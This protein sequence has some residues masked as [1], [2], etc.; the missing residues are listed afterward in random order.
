MAAGIRHN[1]RD[2]EQTQEEGAEL[3]RDARATGRDEA[4]D[5]AKGVGIV[6]V[7]GL[8]L[9][10]RSAS[11]FHAKF[12][13]AWWT[14]KWINLF[15]NFCVPLF[16]LISAILLARSASRPR[17]S[18]PL[19]ANR[20]PPSSS[21]WRRFAWRR[22]RSVLFPLLIW[23]AIFWLLRAFVRHDVAVMR[24]GYWLDYKGR[25]MDL[26][27]GKAEFHLYFLSILAQFCILLPFLAILFGKFDRSRFRKFLTS[28]WFGLLIAILMQSAA[29]ALQKE[30]RFQW[31]GATVFWYLSILIPGV[32][33]GMN[34]KAW[35]Q[36]RRQTW[37]VWAILAAVGFAVFGTNSALDLQARPTNGTATNAASSA[38][39]LGMSFLILAFL[40]LLKASKSSP[41]P[42]SPA[43]WGGAFRSL[44]K[45]MGELSIQIYLMHPILMQ[46][47][48]LSWRLKLFK[49]LPLPSLWLFLVTLFGTYGVALLLDRL[50]YVNL[51][52]FGKEARRAGH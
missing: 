23:S 11:L 8:H 24:P 18:A 4:F 5:I 26:A 32:W 28:I 46:W 44:V 3:G 17:S 20:Q 36:V 27:F 33:V 14:L 22:I 19:T 45:R 10:S 31:P 40:T 52:L 42:Y 13:Q 47:L 37:A 12:D 34:W 35:P 16:L 29:F 48:G 43:L 30:V 38:Y 41:P 25:L 15:L 50:P 9:S 1:R 39:A 21:Y 51:V 2:L 49:A 7:V 6:A